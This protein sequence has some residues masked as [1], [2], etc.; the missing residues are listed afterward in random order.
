MKKQSW[1]KEKKVTTI[2]ALISLI[3][4]FLFIGNG[5]I[6]GNVI[7]NS[8]HPISILSI[9]GLLLIFCS[10]ALAIYTINKK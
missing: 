6:T 7:I 8:Y 1:F 10:V 4:G 2:L 9:I 3:A 5:G